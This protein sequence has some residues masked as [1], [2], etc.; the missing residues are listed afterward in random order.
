MKIYQ[1]DAALGYKQFAF[2]IKLD[3]SKRGHNYLCIGTQNCG[4]DEGYE[5]G[6]IVEDLEDIYISNTDFRLEDSPLIGSYLFEYWL[7]NQSKEEDKGVEG[8]F[9]SNYHYKG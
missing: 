5:I 6:E 7:K 4:A 1:T 8:F 3:K 9:N 2:L